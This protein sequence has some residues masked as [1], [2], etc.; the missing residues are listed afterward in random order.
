MLNA[1]GHPVCTYSA[2]QDS[3]GVKGVSWSPSGDLLALG[4]YD[5]VRACA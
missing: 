3:L 4:S 2:Y 5:Q 1:L